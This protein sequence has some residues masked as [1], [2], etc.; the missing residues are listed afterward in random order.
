MIQAMEQNSAWWRESVNELFDVIKT[1]NDILATGFKH[2]GRKI[3]LAVLEAMRFVPN[4]SDDDA[5]EPVA[6]EV[7]ENETPD[8][9]EEQSSVHDLE[10]EY[11]DEVYEDKLININEENC[12]ADEDKAFVA[13]KYLF[14]D[15]FNDEE[16]KY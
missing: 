6:T 4:E 7:N 15:D 11:K 16:L 9:D 1:Q 8:I 10:E 2:V 5:G 13:V 12:G 14:N 3:R